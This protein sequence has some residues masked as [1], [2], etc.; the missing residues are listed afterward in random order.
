LEQSRECGVLELFRQ[1]GI[2]ELLRQYGILELVRKCGI[3][4]LSKN[5][6]VERCKIDTVNTQMDD[7]TLSWLGTVL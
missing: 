7:R 2:L 4:E 3:L 5:N 6:I 1:Y